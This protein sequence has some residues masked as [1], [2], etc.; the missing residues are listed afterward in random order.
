MLSLATHKTQTIVTFSGSARLE[1]VGLGRFI[2]AWA[3]QSYAYRLETARSGSMYSCVGSFPVGPAELTETPLSAS[4]PPITV[5]ASPGIRPAGP[6]C[7]Y[8]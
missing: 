8:A 5:A 7:V 3:Q 4:V 1:G 6:G 2:L